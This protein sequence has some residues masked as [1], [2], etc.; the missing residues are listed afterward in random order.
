MKKDSKKQ[1]KEKK[2]KTIEL[3]NVM[4]WT[5][6]NGGNVIYL[7]QDE[8]DPSIHELTIITPDML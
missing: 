4:Q 1:K 7:E 5:L 2:T 3:D 8:K 6:R